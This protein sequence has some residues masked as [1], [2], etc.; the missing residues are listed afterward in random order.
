MVTVSSGGD[1]R[2][3]ARPRCERQLMAGLMAMV[4]FPMPSCQCQ[5][6]LPALMIAGLLPSLIFSGKPKIA[7]LDVAL[8]F[9]SANSNLHHKHQP[10][11]R[12]VARSSNKLWTHVDVSGS[13]GWP[14]SVL[15]ADFSVSSRAHVHY[16]RAHSFGDRSSTCTHTAF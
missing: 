4:Y 11:N 16:V 8:L 9:P 6:Q 10:S 15:L 7:H 3:S 12:R 2:A 13:Y 5:H 14:L 1:E